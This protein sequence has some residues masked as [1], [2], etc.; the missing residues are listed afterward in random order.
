MFID[1]NVVWPTLGVKDLNLVKTVKTLERLGYTAIA[2]NYQYDGKLQNVIKNPIVKE[3]YPEQKIKIYSRITLTIES[4]P[5]NKVLSNVTKEFDILAIR[6]IGDRLL[7]QT[8]SD[9][10]FDILSIDFTQRL[11]FYLKHTFMGLAVSRDIGIE[12]SY[13]SGLRDVSNRRNLITN[14][15]SLVRA[16][17]GRGIIVTS[18]TRTPLECRAGFDV[19]NLATF[20]DLKQDQARKSVGESCRSVLLHAETRRDTYR[21]ILNGCH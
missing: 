20:W 14:A 8:C 19:I 17:R 10:E 6:P 18:E 3:L 21:S 11:P 16:T 7:Q 1:L 12:I 13:S 2:L 15:T 4:M 9:L 5:Q